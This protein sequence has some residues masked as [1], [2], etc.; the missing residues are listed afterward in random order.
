[1]LDLLAFE[2][3][4]HCTAQGLLPPALIKQTIPAID[5][6]YGLQELAVHKQKVRVLLGDD[7]L[8]AAEREADQ[9]GKLLSTLRNMLAEL[10]DGSA[11]FLQCF[12][13]AQGMSL[14]P[15]TAAAAAAADACM[16]VMLKQSFA[17]LQSSSR[18][19][20]VSKD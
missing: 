7:A 16:S 4:G 19:F 14:C 18:H 11:P 17:M 8:A 5:T 3:L 13:L 12:N 9:R 6:A 15:N 2:R 1:M 20:I 10:P